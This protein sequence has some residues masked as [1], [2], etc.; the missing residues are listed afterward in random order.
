MVSVFKN[1]VIHLRQ[2]IKF[3]IILA[4]GLV[5][6]FFIVFYTYK[7]VYAVTI[8][9]EFLGYTSDKSE[10]QSKINEYMQSGDS[11]NVA[12]VDI[13]VLPEYSFCLVKRDFET[14]DDEIFSEIIETGITYYKYYAILVDSEEKYYVSTFQECEDIIDSLTEQDSSNKDSISYIV[15]YETELQELIDTETAVANLYVEKEEETVEETTSSTTTLSSST[16]LG[17]V[18]TSSNISYSAIDIGITLIKPV[19]GT[20]TSRFGSVSSIRSSVHTGLDIGA[21]T[22]TPILA[23]A[24][25]TVVYS[26]WKSSYGYLITIDHG[27]NVLTYYAHCSALYK[28]VGEYVTQG[29]TIAAVGSTGNSTGPH[30]HIE[31]RVNGVA[32]NPANYISY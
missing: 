5:I 31:V 10:L 4:I 8:S 19:S 18:V 23:A 9:D 22:G 26:G 29:E 27:N 15:K 2:W 21:S 1:L 11:E 20:I 7:P 24:S 3:L 25:G 16:T 14:S 32:Y 28:S 12:F 30:L 6:I 13:E 17:T